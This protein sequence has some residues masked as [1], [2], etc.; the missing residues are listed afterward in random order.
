MGRFAQMTAKTQIGWVNVRYRTGYCEDHPFLAPPLVQNP[1]L[2]GPGSHRIPSLEELGP[3][4]RF[5]QI[6]GE[7]ARRLGR[8]GDLTTSYGSHLMH[9]AIRYEGGFELNH[10]TLRPGASD[11]AA[12]EG[13]RH[14]MPTWPADVDGV[15]FGFMERRGK[16]FV[17]VRA[18]YGDADV[19][20]A[21]A[22]PIDAS[23]HLNGRRV[24]AEAITLSDGSAGALLGDMIEANP[25]Q[26]PALVAVREQIREALDR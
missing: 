13:G 16:R 19:V 5:P 10:P 7:R 23:R 9:H 21:N 12:D 3:S 2:G 22:V 11:F 20:L 14:P 1:V 4:G 26:R 18:Q 17:A 24:S 15:R 8:A 25:A 6:L